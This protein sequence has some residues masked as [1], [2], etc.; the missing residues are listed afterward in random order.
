MGGEMRNREEEEEEELRSHS[1]QI[2]LAP[3]PRC[4]HTRTRTGHSLCHSVNSQ[5][6]MSSANFMQYP[7]CS[8]V[9]P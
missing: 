4:T 5:R 3:W 8:L 6:R 9:Y 2:A 7:K 1:R